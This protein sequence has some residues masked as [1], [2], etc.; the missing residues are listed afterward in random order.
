MA[1]MV[2]TAN[3]PP[4]RQTNAITARPKRVTPAISPAAPRARALATSRITRS[5]IPDS[6]TNAP[7]ATMAKMIE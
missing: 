7:S 3:A 2:R 1:I 6:A 4:I 5:G